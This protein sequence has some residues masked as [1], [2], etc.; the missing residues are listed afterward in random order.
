MSLTD[1][2]RL[3]ADEYIRT[4]NITQS[5]MVAY[6]HIKKESS[7]AT[8]GSRLLRNAKVKTYVDKRLDKLK[9]QSIAEQDEILQFLTSVV[10]GEKTEQ[11]PL[12]M[13]E[14]YQELKDKEPTIKDRIK[15]AE[16]LGK[17]YMMWTEKHRVESDMQVTIVDDIPVSDNNENEPN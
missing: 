6:P 15:A 7:A 14:G 13:G 8:S 3:F 12:G 10:R 2:Q 1:Q 16:L 4:G 9:K 5:Y 17:R 11:I